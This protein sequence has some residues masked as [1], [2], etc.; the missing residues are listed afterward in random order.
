MIAKIVVVY[1][2]M[3]LTILFICDLISLSWGFLAA[4][5]YAIVWDV[6]PCPSGSDF[7]V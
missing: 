6:M 3:I 1:F 4:I 5:V 2:K 7:F